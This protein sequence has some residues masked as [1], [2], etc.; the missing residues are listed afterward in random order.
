M[1]RLS[2]LK[3]QLMEEANKRILN[4]AYEGGI[5]QTGDDSCNIRCK[6]KLAKSGSNGDVIKY[7]QHLLAANEFNP[8]YVGGGI[9]KECSDL[10]EGCDGKYR[11]HTKDAVM[12]FQRKYDETPDG[13][14]GYNTLMKMCEVFKPLSATRTE[15]VKAYN[16]LCK[17]CQCDKQ[18]QPIGGDEIDTPSPTDDSIVDDIDVYN[19]IN[20]VKCDT[21][22]SCVYKYILTDR[23]IDNS[24][25]DGGRKVD[26]E[27]FIGCLGLNNIDLPINPKKGCTDSAGNDLC[28]MIPEP[29]PPGGMTTAVM[30]YYYHPSEGK[31]VS[32]SGGPA[33]FRQMKKCTECCERK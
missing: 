5:I 15:T 23:G 9:G 8:K 3:R 30:G 13:I 6:R 24:K 25:L 33:P 31:C 29:I 4:E 1:G 11:R 17:D 14:V 27:G 28:K 19:P 20:K 7:I 10:Y 12:E 21:L 32:V 26:Y 22:K 2:K 18:D 16:L